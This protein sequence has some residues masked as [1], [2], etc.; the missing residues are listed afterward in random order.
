MKRIGITVFFRKVCQSSVFLCSLFVLF[1]FAF[2]DFEESKVSIPWTDF[3]QILKQLKPDTIREEI[4]S[5]LPVKFVVAEAS[6]EGKKHDQGEFIFSAQLQINVLEPEEWVTI[7]LGREIAIF[8][9]IK[10]NGK[11]AMVGKRDNGS[12]YLMVQGGQARYTIQY[13]FLVFQSIVSGQSSLSF[14]MPGQTVARITLHLDRPSYTVIANKRTLTMK[15]K[16]KNRYVYKGALGTGKRAL[17]SWQQGTTMI[18]KQ[19]AMVIGKFHTIYSLGMGIMHLRSQINLNIIHQ[20]IRQFS[21]FLPRHLDIINLTGKSL[22]TW[23]TKDSANQQKVTAY[24]K[25]SIRDQVPF[26]LN[27]EMSYNDSLSRIILPAITLDQAVRQEGIIGVGVLSN[28]EIK[29]LDHSNNVLKRDKR[30]L[31]RWFSDQGDILH[32]YQYLSDDYHI[33]LSLTPHGNIPVLEALITK[34]Q[35]NSVIRQDGKMITQMDLW[36]RNRGEQF[37]R[38]DWKPQWQLW[39]V[40][41]GNEPSRPAYD[42]AKG[43][44]L[45]PLKKASDKTAESSI[46]MVYL[47][48]H[49]QFGLIGKQGI[50]YPKINM[51]LQ[52]IKGTLY[53]PKSV[54]PF[55]LKGNLYAQERYLRTRTPWFSSFFKPAKYSPRVVDG[56]TGPGVFFE[57]APKVKEGEESQVLRPKMRQ[58]VEKLEKKL[59][60]EPEPEPL[61]GQPEKMDRK[62]K[63]PSISALQDK[64]VGL[65]QDFQQMLSQSLESGQLSI[66]VNIV[67]AGKPM[68]LSSSMLKTVETPS[69][70]FRFH[71]IPRKTP[72]W[73]NLLVFLLTL[74]ASIVFTLCLWLKPDRK[75]IVYGIII[76]LCIALLI[77]RFMDKSLMLDLLYLVPGCFLFL[78][79]VHYMKQK[80]LAW[81]KKR[82]QKK[83]IVKDEFPEGKLPPEISQEEK[84]QTNTDTKPDSTVNDQQ[85]GEN[86]GN[87]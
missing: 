23:E 70:S 87:D 24:L 42:T 62:R 79:L 27:A 50:E 41:E 38:L 28:V 43:E 69:L 44:L 53:V 84:P 63:S 66:P 18:S 57:S 68:P 77:Q 61:A 1:T 73:L 40:Y 86:T 59:K 45:I 52:G 47:S 17:L 16:G 13:R 30:E 2:D 22:A 64:D 33:E 20:D 55:L 34:A 85:G 67:F 80:I 21:F 19:Q 74:L 5:H 65:E 56:F 78:A 72:A 7:E 49:K 11:P 15:A 31:P 6:Y 8:P 39:S 48:S 60:V 76:P 36:V 12:C 26:L 82:Q 4:P 83:Q 32:V 81:F 3:K 35:I 37:L 71:Q 75:K 54:R 46:R 29:P 58:K 10:V 9:E 51:P 25:Y 14:P